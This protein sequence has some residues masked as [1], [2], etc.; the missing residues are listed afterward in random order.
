MIEKLFQNFSG[1]GMKESK[2]CQK[3]IFFFV[4]KSFK[5]YV[6]FG[7]CTHFILLSVWSKQY[8]K[9]YLNKIPEKI[10]LR[11]DKF[12]QLLILLI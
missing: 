9:N 12:A 11:R 8:L 6:S 4:A 5:I 3:R 10:T 1:L 7:F 2:G